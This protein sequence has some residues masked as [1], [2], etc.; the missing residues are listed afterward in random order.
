[1]NLMNEPNETFVWRTIGDSSLRLSDDDARVETRKCL[2]KFVKDCLLSKN[3]SLYVALVCDR[4][5]EV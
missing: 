5:N 2:G 4:T 1:M 3:G